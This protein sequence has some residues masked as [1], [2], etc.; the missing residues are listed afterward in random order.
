MSTKKNEII[1]KINQL[2]KKIIEHN[3]N[4]HT[5]DNPKISD[6]EYDALYSELKKLKMLS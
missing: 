2:T 4:Y 6:E 5:Y 1:N 3:E